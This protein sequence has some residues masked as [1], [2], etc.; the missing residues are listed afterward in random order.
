MAS[1]DRQSTRGTCAYARNCVTSA[2]VVVE[3]NGTYFPD[4]PRKKLGLK[5]CG[6]FVVSIP[7]IKETPRGESY[8]AFCELVWMFVLFGGNKERHDVN[9]LPAFSFKIRYRRINRRNPFPSF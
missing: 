6:R 8:I 2:A 3:R 9:L 5:S 7:H 1:V 4:T